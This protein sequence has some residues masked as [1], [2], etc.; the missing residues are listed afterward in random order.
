MSSSQNN[1]KIKSLSTNRYLQKLKRNQIVNTI[2]LEKQEI[3]TDKEIERILEKYIS[4]IKK[5]RDIRETVFS[6]TETQFQ[7]NLKTD[8][9]SNNEYRNVIEINSA[10]RKNLFQPDYRNH[11]YK[12][13][14]YKDHL[15]YKT[16]ENHK[17]VDEMT[18]QKTVPNQNFP[19][20]QNNLFK[21]QSTPDNFIQEKNLKMT[22][23]QE[24]LDSEKNQQI[25]SNPHPKS[26]QVLNFIPKEI[27]DPEDLPNNQSEVKQ[28]SITKKNPKK[29]INKIKA[30][31][32]ESM[33]DPSVIPQKKKINQE[34]LKGF[35]NLTEIEN[36]KQV[37][38]K[39]GI[40]GAQKSSHAEYTKEKSLQMEESDDSISSNAKD[41]SEI[42]DKITEIP[43]KIVTKPKPNKIRSEYFDLKR[44]QKQEKKFCSEVQ[45]NIKTQNTESHIKNQFTQKNLQKN[46][47]KILEQITS[48]DANQKKKFE[49]ENNDSNLRSKSQI[50]S[51]KSSSYVEDL[52]SSQKAYSE[53]N[54]KNK[55]RVT[56]KTMASLSYGQ[57]EF[58]SQIV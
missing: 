33:Y 25:E 55:S 26:S 34:I 11:Q 22:E 3:I 2:D 6:K 42:A 10:Q 21:V 14:D 39:K 49:F 30:I 37:D 54:I 45:M 36:I 32:I 7:N 50:G 1:S 19:N 47:N 31:P 56:S 29:I 8:T 17:R 48:I 38:L 4:E 18:P 44:D 53:I 57:K 16:T 12:K 20:S 51:K 15:Y 23:N 9:E 5:D 13:N 41:S 27:S 24:E 28:T 52:R 40:F 35:S 46:E 43:N 58:K